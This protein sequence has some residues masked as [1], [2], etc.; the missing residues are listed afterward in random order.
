MAFVDEAM[1]VVRR[2]LRDETFRYDAGDVG[3]VYGSVHLAIGVVHAL[4][5]LF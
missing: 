3:R 1:I 2:D 4:H 5:V